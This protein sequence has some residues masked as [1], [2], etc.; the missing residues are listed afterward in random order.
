[1]QRYITNKNIYYNI[2]YKQKY[3]RITSTVLSLHFEQPWPTLCFN[4]LSR[5]IK[6]QLHVSECPIFILSPV[7]F[8]V[9]K[10]SI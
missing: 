3:K 7:E 4:Y 2:V 10:L 6:S 5:S 1:M 8:L 9:N